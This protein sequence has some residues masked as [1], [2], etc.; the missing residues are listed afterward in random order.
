MSTRLA[1]V[2]LVQ[3]LA[4]SAAAPALAAGSTTCADWKPNLVN[5]LLCK[6]GLI[7]PPQPADPAPQPEPTPEPTPAPADPVGCVHFL[8]QLRR[9]Q[10]GPLKVGATDELCER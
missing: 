10:P 7:G 6:L 4:G 1:A 8:R 9:Y 5:E 2:V 3:V